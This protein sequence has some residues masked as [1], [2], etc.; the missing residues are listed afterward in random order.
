MALAL[1]FTGLLL[2]VLGIAGA[3]LAYR[4]MGRADS[5]HRVL[6]TTPTTA[7]AATPP[8]RVVEIQGTVVPS[9]QGVLVS[10]PSGREAV[11]YELEVLDASGS[12][13]TE[14]S[15]KHR[16]EFW[17]RDSSGD[18][19]RILPEGCEPIVRMTRYTEGQ[20]SPVA[21][22]DDTL[23]VPM[24]P[25]A[26]GW[27]RMVTG[28]EIRQLLVEERLIA[29]GDELFAMGFGERNQDGTL[30]LSQ[31][32]GQKLGLDDVDRA[33]ISGCSTS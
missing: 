9:E 8:G 7:I 13:S 32:A 18:H 10:P 21:L 27:A 14:H 26:R 30:Y 12:I 33:R 23:Y 17:L 29:P 1:L 5:T 4:Q 20:T 15:A 24:T 22:R 3:W 6:V 28:K 31:K 16:R 11:L 25:Q 2:I 19:A